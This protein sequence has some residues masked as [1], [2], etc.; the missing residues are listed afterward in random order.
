M[1]HT[2]F[3]NLRFGQGEG[4]GH[5]LT[6]GYG[7]YP[8]FLVPRKGNKT[9]HNVCDTVPFLDDPAGDFRMDTENLLFK[10]FFNSID[11]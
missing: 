7:I 2:V 8:A 5:D 1:F 10:D 9:P 11:D 3:L 4:F 6:D